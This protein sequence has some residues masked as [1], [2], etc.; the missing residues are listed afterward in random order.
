M[1]GSAALA[2]CGALLHWLHAGVRCT[3]C[4]RGSAALAACGSLL[5]WLHAGV[6]CTGCMQVS[7]ALAACG[8]LLHW[9][10]A[11][12]EHGPGVQARESHRAM[13]N[14]LD[15]YNDF[16]SSESDDVDFCNTKKRPSLLLASL[17]GP[18][19]EKESA[20]SSMDLSEGYAGYGER[21][22][23]YYPYGDHQEYYREQDQS[24]RQT[25]T[26]LRS[27]YKEV[28]SRSG[29]EVDPAME[30][31]LHWDSPSDMDTVLVDSES[32]EPP[33]PKVP[34][35]ALPRRLC[36]RTSRW[37]KGACEGVLSS[38]EDTPS[39]K[40]RSPKAQAPKLK[41]R[42]GKKA[43]SPVPAPEMGQSA[44]AS[45]EAR[46]WKSVKRDPVQPRQT[47]T[48]R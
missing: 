37:P 12:G 1:R 35:R 4:M 11:V 44:M 17:F 46:A 13:S 23:S 34:P 22:G 26:D 14:K 43:A 20:G 27:E 8:S 33:V 40:D 47:P 32:G 29:S 42:K 48:S 5:H 24:E 16:Q 10:H 15:W 21:R 3:D 6:R 2:A 36:S 18:A 38:E 39:A 45:P 25:D 28:S 31:A 30:V 41:P 9:L 19:V 7:A